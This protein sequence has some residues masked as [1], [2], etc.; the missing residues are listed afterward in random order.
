[1][2]L[3]NLNLGLYKH[4]LAAKTNFHHSSLRIHKTYLDERP[5]NGA[6]KQ[7]TPLCLLRLNACA[8]NFASDAGSILQN[9][10]LPGSS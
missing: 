1:M 6:L 2:L 4:G 9:E 3:V 5:P 10:P 8:V 7:G